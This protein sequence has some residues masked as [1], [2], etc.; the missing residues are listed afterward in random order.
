MPQFSLAHLT[1]LK[2]TPP[3]LTH[4]AASAGYDYVGFRTIPLGLPNEPD[5]RLTNPA[6]LAELKTAL[7][8]TGM[9]ALDI[10]LARIVDGVDVSTYVPEMEAAAELGI[11]QAVSSVW[12]AD[13]SY[14]VDSL[15]RLCELAAKISVTINLEFVTWTSVGTL[16]DAVSL[17]RELN[18][19]NCGLLVDTLHFSRS[20]VSLDELSNVPR[21]WFHTVHL[22]DAPAEVPSKREDL[23]FTAR[24]ARLDPG[25]G[26]IDLA[27]ILNHIPEVP[28]SLEL[29]NSA[30]V[31][32]LGYAEHVR[33]ALVNAKNYLSTHPREAPV[34]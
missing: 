31:E 2:C 27:A 10:E 7:R 8:R 11:Q 25:Q 34:G 18:Q 26:G 28:Y 19:P 3:E 30:R 32:K 9:K 16:R 14:A 13:R 1:A 5:Y 17:I 15:G 12:T 21:S 24:E 6:L 29:P 20:R 22:C 23:I 4:L 33:L